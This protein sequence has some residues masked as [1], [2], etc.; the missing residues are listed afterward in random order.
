MCFLQVWKR[1]TLKSFVQRVHLISSNEGLLK[2]ELHHTQKDFLEKNDFP[3]W[4]IKQIIAKDEQKNKH[5]NIQ[6]NHNS[7]IN[8]EKENKRP[9]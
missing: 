8:A 7:V 2:T 1:G 5:K 9:C 4:F 6:G 3:L